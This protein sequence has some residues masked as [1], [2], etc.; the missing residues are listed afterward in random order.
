MAILFMEG[1][2]AYS[3][4]NDLK[5][6]PRFT[7]AQTNLANHSFVTG[8]GGSGQAHRIA[9]RDDYLGCVLPQ[10]SSST[11]WMQ[12]GV[13]RQ[14][15]DDG[16]IF[17]LYNKGGTLHG[18]LYI[19][20]TGYL[21]YRTGGSTV[22]GTGGIHIPLNSWAFIELKVTIDNSAGTVLV[23]VDG[24]TDLNLSSQDTLNGTASADIN[25][26]RLSKNI[27][28][29][30]DFDDLV[31]GDDSGTDATDLLRD[32]AIEMLLPDGAGN[33]TQF[34]PS[35]GSNYQ[36]VD[37]S[38]EDGDTTYNSSSTAGHKDTFTCGNLVA[39]SGSIYAVQ[40]G[41]V[42]RR[43]DGGGRNI[44]S[45]VRYSATDANGTGRY[46]P[47]G[48][49]HRHDIYENDPSGSDWTVTSVNAMEIGYNLE[50]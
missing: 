8:R 20:S 5:E 45:M 30:V 9:F 42:A 37:E 19:T 29:A 14:V 24:A 35:T 11:V 27:G 17:E 21:Q 18:D 13:Y 2:E 10:T 25:L 41:Y 12:V 38:T 39:T 36:N 49:G 34:T 43:E 47:S 32:C 44:R 50:T 6:D 15:E 16:S 28:N 40:V 23:K 1:F 7:F 26:V 48:Y 3:V 4:A 46:V 31:I 22:L 33:Y